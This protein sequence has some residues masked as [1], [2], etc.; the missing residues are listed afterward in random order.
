MWQLLEIFGKDIIISTAVEN[1]QEMLRPTIPS[2]IPIKKGKVLV[3]FAGK[4][5]NEIILF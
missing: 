5:I 2:G 3:S 4:Q 1:Y